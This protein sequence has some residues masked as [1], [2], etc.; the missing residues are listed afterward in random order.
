[1]S[2]EDYL[3]S[4]LYQPLEFQPL[5][6]EEHKEIVQTFAIG[7]APDNIPIRIIK[8]TLDIIVEPLKLKKLKGLL[9]S[10]ESGCS[11]TPLK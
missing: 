1:M 8:L 4:P 2:F 6:S 7:K 10:L 11:Q 3:M 9:T 5:V